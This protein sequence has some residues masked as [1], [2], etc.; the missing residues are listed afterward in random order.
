MA[1]AKRKRY[2]Y[3]GGVMTYDKVATRRFVAATMASTKNK[4]RSNI[5]HQFRKR[6]GLE[7]FV[8]ITLLGDVKEAD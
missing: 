1:E 5:A 6:M 8:R 7:S 2:T 3:E 4:A